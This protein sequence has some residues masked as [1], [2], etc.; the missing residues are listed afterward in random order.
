MSR[1][2]FVAMPTY[3]GLVPI[4]TFTCL[5]GTYQECH[6]EGWGF[7]DVR[8][9]SGDADIARARNSFVGIFLK[10]D[11][12]DF[13]MIDGDISW[14]PG[15]FVRLVTH[16]VPF[17]GAAYR[18]RTDDVY[19][20]PITYKEPRVLNV[21]NPQRPLVEVVG[22]PLGFCRLTRPAVEL[23]VGSLQG[24][25]FADP[26]LPDDDLPWL[27]DFEQHQ[28]E[29][30]LIRMEEGYALCNRW[31]HL[32]GQAWIDPSIKLGHTGLKTFEGDLMDEMRKEMEKAQL[33][34]AE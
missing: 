24:R 22:M 23:L 18:M 8:T 20:Y 28:D 7:I 19:H 13:V 11:W 6:A 34:A 27:I 33:Q 21:D 10:G 16:E 3:T 5:L 17:V 26:M 15:A 32:G 31:R 4:P 14:G 2:I 25:K 1:K 30:G 12:T 29:R 9:R